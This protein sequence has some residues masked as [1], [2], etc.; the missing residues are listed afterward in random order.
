MAGPAATFA[1]GQ[2]L[3]EAT[4]REFLD[5][6]TALKLHSSEL[7]LSVT[8]QLLSDV[9]RSLKGVQLT[10]QIAAGKIGEI[11]RCFLAEI[12]SQAFF[13]VPSNRARFYSGLKW[14][15]PPAMEPVAPPSPPFGEEVAVNFPSASYDI[16]EAGNCYAVGRN[17]GCVFHLMNVLGVGLSALG[18]KFGV[19]LANT[20]WAPAI[21]EIESKIR[22]MHKDPAWKIQSD[23]KQ[24][25]E[26]YAQAASHFG[27]LKDAW[28]NYTA[29]GRAKFDEGEA[30]TILR[31][32]RGFMQKLAMR[33]HE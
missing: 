4:Y 12:K 18:M 1:P 27:V 17:T 9:A 25:Q 7:G 3:N 19:S 15:D 26:F 28:R 32:M 11:Y 2:P 21:E 29:H 10:R 5:S 20:N 13:F 23:C 14:P 22:Y 24:Q 8:E 33:L 30:E 6:L 16:K 31:N